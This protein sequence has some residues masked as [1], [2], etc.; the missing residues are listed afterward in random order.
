MLKF[1][2]T[3]DYKKTRSFLK[4][5][6]NFKLK[7]LE[8]YGEMGLQALVDSTPVDT[9]LTAAS[10]GYKIEQSNGIISISWTNSN[11]SNGVPVAILIQYGHV[12]KNG[13]Y[14]QGIDY[15]NPALK[16]VFEQ[17]AKSAW[18]EVMNG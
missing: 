17:I 11:V 7:D 9:A 5:L 1:K 8:K 15:I 14:V 6:H 4:R 18:Y 3:G 12:T 16:P 13:G 2:V 10:W